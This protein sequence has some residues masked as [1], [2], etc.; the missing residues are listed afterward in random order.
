MTI[1][2]N[3]PDLL[4][5]SLSQMQPALPRVILESFAVQGYRQGILSTAQVRTLLAHDS[6][7]ETEDFLAA[8]DA[9]PDPSAAEVAAGAK[10]LRDAFAA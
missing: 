5:A 8:H 1:T 10:S 6:R 7:W 4:A 3:I 2:L 9:W